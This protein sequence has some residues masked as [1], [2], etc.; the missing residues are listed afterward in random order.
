MDNTKKDD[1]SLK[2]KDWAF[3]DQYKN[4]LGRCYPIIYIET[5]RQKLIEDVEKAPTPKVVGL[6]NIG[7]PIDVYEMSREYLKEHVKIIINKRF[8][9]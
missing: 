7:N 3:I 4:D 9:V 8:G 2:D 1:W 5:L 6:E